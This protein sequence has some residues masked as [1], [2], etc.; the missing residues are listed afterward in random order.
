[1]AFDAAWVRKVRLTSGVVLMLFVLTHFLNHA[2]GLISFDAL[3]AGRRWFLWV[4]RNPAGTVILYA[5]LLLHLL[6]ALWA[7]Y[8]RRSFRLKAVDWIQLGLGFAIPLILVLHI[9]GTR[10]AASFFGTED[11]Y[12]YTLTVLFVLV[13]E[14]GMQQIALMLIVWL[15]GAVGLHMWLR[16][17]LWYR[18]LQWFWYALAL[19]VPAA[20]LA[21]TWVAVRDLIH[22]MAEPGQIER[23]MAEV[24]APSP[25]IAKLIYDIERG[26]LIGL[27]LALAITLISRP[28]RNRLRAQLGLVRIIYPNGRRV[29]VP[30]GVTILEASRQAG[31]PHASVCGGRGRCSTCRVRVGKGL[32]ALSQPSAEEQRVLNR[33]GAAANV[34][35]ACQTPAEADCE[36]TPLLPAATGPENVGP[37]PGYR[38]GQEREVTVLFADLREFTAFSEEKLPYDVVFLL[39]RY[40][41]SMGSAIERS[42]GRVDKFIGDGVM[43]L[44]GLETTPEAGSR[45][46]IA[47]ARSMATE[48]DRLNEGLRQELSRPLRMGIGLHRGPAIVGEMGYGDARSI[49]AV[50]DTVNTASRLESLTKEFGVQLVVSQSVAD[51][52]G[53]AGSFEEREISVRGRTRP[54][55]VH[56]VPDAAALP[57]T[58]A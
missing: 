25:E 31:V 10:V 2:L 34:R 26:I 32:N 13:P 19:I 47:A 5:S 15:H 8:E 55:V 22:L 24:R 9:L 14:L 58:G 20:A 40:F 46:A 49:T 38:Q 52:G 41:A 11:N 3:E 48:L 21:G 50:G 51:G 1:M 29:T 4:W 42:G 27:G 45:A 54:L 36:V 17:K 53:L 35:L 12:L 23:T 16:L 33:V 57:Q 30:R 37:E 7:L 6:L 56:L 39:N 44:F 43:A 18:R 28:I